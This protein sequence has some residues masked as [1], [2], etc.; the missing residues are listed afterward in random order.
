[1][2]RRDF[3]KNVSLTGMAAPFLWNDMNMQAVN[4]MLFGFSKNAEDRVLV[5]IRMN[6]GNDGLNMVIPLDSYDNLYIHRPNVII[7]E[8]EVLNLSNEVGLHP[9]MTGMRDMY[10]NGN[11]GIVQNVGYPEQNRSHFRSMDIWTSGM[12]EPSDT[13]GWLGRSFDKEY[14]NYPADFPNATHPDPFAISMGND[15]S[16]T[17]QGLM[18]NF[19]HAVKDPFAV[20]DLEASS[21]LNDGTYFGSHIEYIST[22]IN[23]SNAYGLEV[24]NAANEGNT[25]SSLYDDNNPLAVQLRYVAQMISGGLQTKVYVLNINGFDTHDSQ[26]NTGDTSNGNHA[27]LLKNVSDAIAAFQDDINLLGLQNRVAGMTFSE[28]GRQVKSNASNG[29]DH[30]DA[31]PLFLFGSCL[32]TS[33]IGP[34]PVIP[35]SVPNQAGVPMQIDFRDIYASILKDWFEV[36]SKEVQSLFEHPVTFYPVLSNCNVSDLAEKEKENTAILLYPNPATSKT[37]IRLTCG[38]EW[39]RIEA[40]D[41]TGSNIGVLYDDNLSAGEHNIPIDVHYWSV[42]TYRIR[43]IK[44]SGNGDVQLLKVSY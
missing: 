31:A 1:M 18:G 4:K 29:T 9:A 24:N 41:V 6:G 36:D 22:L 5:L 15:V 43:V 19:S 25:L 32:N 20:V 8:N 34:N 3:L 17:C 40:F 10:T 30:G 16:T 42:G 38:N 11:L 12:M 23:Q 35:S 14:P 33:I 27:F 13:S 39:V 28:F 2:K 37:T 26:V 21:A 44:T 7:P